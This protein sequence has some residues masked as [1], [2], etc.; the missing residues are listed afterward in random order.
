MFK[1]SEFQI[2][3]LE[4]QVHFGNAK[5]FWTWFKGEIKYL[6]SEKTSPKT[7]NIQKRKL[8]FQNIDWDFKSFG[9]YCN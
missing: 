6:S 1:T 5:T 2:N 9:Q 3:V 4:I 7:F 8:D